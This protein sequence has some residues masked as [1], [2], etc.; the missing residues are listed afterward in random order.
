[1]MHITI[2]CNISKWTIISL[3]VDYN[4]PNAIC[5]TMFTKY[6][7]LVRLYEISVFFLFAGRGSTA[8]TESSLPRGNHDSNSRAG[9]NS[10]YGRRP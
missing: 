7:H 3:H 8:I 5:K 4:T 9:R 1:M 10:A 2:L 6:D